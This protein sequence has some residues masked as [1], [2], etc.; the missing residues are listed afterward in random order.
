[1]LQGRE[2]TAYIKNW[3]QKLNTQLQ[4]NEKISFSNYLITHLV[5]FSLQI[6]NLLP[7]IELLQSYS[8]METVRSNGA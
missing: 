8:N 7:S 3:I 4:D 2:L 6:Q 1:M 5:I